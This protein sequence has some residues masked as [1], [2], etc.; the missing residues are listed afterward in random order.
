MATQF[1]IDCALMAGDSYISTRPDIN[2]FP[3]PTGWAKVTNP[4]SYF[5]DPSTGF[6]AVSFI[7]GTEIV[8][9]YAG[10]GTA[11]D[12]AANIG[13]ATGYGS[14]QLLQAAEYYLQVKAA[15][16]NANITF[17]GHSLGGGL[18]ALMGVFFAKQAV[19]FDQA[20]FA[21]SA[22]DSS[23]IS[24]PLN[25]LVPD[26][27]A[28]LKRDLVA[29]GYS[30]ADLSPLTSFLIVRPTNGGIPNLNLVTDI[31]VQGEVLSSAPVTLYNRIGTQVDI[32]NSANGVSGTDLHS[33]A[34]LAAFLQSNQSAA[35]GSNPQHTLNEVTKK[36]T[37]LLGMIF[38][39]NLYYND[40]NN[41]IN[42]QRNFLENLV[43]HEAGIT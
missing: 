39:K 10:T 15:N 31:N 13:L 26:V 6:E 23:F 37:D 16:P 38:D 8:I 35:I 28:N 25:L 43:R 3:I 22:Q 20:P 9:S 12:W 1:E 32:A 29:K 11:I 33:Q 14:D 30:A 5:I 27:A 19:T 17:T 24:N 36:L 4:D 7:K 2:K 41:K 40:P 18:A 34:L 21:N 42:P